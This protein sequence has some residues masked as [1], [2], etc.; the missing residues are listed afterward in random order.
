MRE[1][2]LLVLVVGLFWSAGVLAGNFPVYQWAPESQT[3]MHGIH[4]ISGGVGITESIMEENRLLHN[5]EGAVFPGMNNFG[6]HTAEHELL[7]FGYPPA[8]DN[9]SAKMPCFRHM[10]NI[11]GN[12]CAP[13]AIGRLFCQR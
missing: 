6:G 12:A 4:F 5:P 10:Q 8:A 1:K 13:A 3:S 9:H 2:I 11:L 7:G